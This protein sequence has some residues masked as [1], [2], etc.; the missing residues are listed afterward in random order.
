MEWLKDNNDSKKNKLQW[1]QKGVK[2]CYC[3]VC[4]KANISAQ[5]SFFQF[6][7]LYLE[8]EIYLYVSFNYKKIFKLN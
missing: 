2:I 8:P 7:V 3:P 4:N 5:C 1:A 6:Y